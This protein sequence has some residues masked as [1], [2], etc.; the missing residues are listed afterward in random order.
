MPTRGRRQDPPTSLPERMPA[1]KNKRAAARPTRSIN[2][3][4]MLSP[5]ETRLVDEARGTFKRGH[6]VRRACVMIARKNMFSDLPRL[7]RDMG[8]APPRAVR[9]TEVGFRLQPDEFEALTEAAG[10]L[11]MPLAAW[12]REAVVRCA[13][14]LVHGNAKAHERFDPVSGIHAEQAS[15]NDA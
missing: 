4:V 3:K 1:R 13:Q 15:S 9:E 11:G 12:M 14:A 5:D 7:K 2:R 10:R 8:S 6:W